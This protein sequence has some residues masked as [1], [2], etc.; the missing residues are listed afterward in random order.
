MLLSYSGFGADT[1]PRATDFET[2]CYR[3]VPT[4]LCWLHLSEEE[5][6]Q[7]DNTE[8]ARENET[9]FELLQPKFSG[10]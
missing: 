2:I 5:R 10:N 6:K 7:H 3:K 9:D 1:Q 4:T 8:I